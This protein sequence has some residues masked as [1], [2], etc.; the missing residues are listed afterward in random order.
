MQLSTLTREDGNDRIGTSCSFLGQHVAF[1]F[2]SL[3]LTEISL[4]L[5]LFQV[6]SL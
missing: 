2:L 1:G 5:K 3:H 6:S 4:R